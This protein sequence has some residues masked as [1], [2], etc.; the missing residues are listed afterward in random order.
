[1]DASTTST[2]A[3]AF[4][5]THFIPLPKD[6]QQWLL[7][8][9]IAHALG[10][11]DEGA[12]SRIYR[13]HA[14]EFSDK[15][16]ETVNLTVS[17]EINGLQYKSARI[18]SLRG[19]HLVAMF[20]RSPRAAEF[21][22]WV[23]DILDK[24]TAAPVPAALEA[25]PPSEVLGAEG[26]ERAEHL[27]ELLESLC[28]ASAPQVRNAVMQGISARAGALPAQV[29]AEHV[30]QF[31]SYLQSAFDAASDL[32]EHHR[33]EMADLMGALSARFQL[34][35]CLSSA[36]LRSM[37]RIQAGRRTEDLYEAFKLWKARPANAVAMSK[38]RY[39]TIV[40]P[41]ASLP[42]VMI[43]MKAGSFVMT[44]DELCSALADPTFGTRDQV[45]KI[46]LTATS[47]LANG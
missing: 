24:E 26:A 4:H 31:S 15:M 41:D 29:S 22:R 16:T 19:A 44:I 25:P 47:R 33:R 10:Y 13:R 9:D 40:T 38:Y 7:A 37:K 17:G 27:I 1:M 32:A 28:G 5:D 12:V 14:G 6:G 18:F 34:G 35:Q 42:P 20:A 45:G 43:P 11:S 36:T 46:A 23:L 39:L 8:V 21:R 3:L 30:E 2:P